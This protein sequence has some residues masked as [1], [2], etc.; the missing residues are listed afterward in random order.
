MPAL[1]LTDARSDFRSRFDEALGGQDANRLAV[2]APR[3]LQTVARR[4][5]AVEQFPR[6]VA[7]GDDQYPKIPRDR[8]VQAERTASCPRVGFR[9]GVARSGNGRRRTRR[10][11]DRL[12]CLFTCHRRLSCL[13][14]LSKLTDRLPVRRRLAVDDRRPPASRYND[15]AFAW[16]PKHDLTPGPP[17]LPAC[18]PLDR[19][20]RTVYSAFMT[21]LF[22]S[23]RS[24]R[25]SR[26]RTSDRSDGYPVDTDS[27]R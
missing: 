3:Y 13:R 25:G 18:V 10:S 5:L 9:G 19:S 17:L 23:L 26:T 22:G 4:D 15:T 7:A 8:S 12:C 11:K 27:C 14:E 16:H 2:G 20:S 21:M 1:R 6:L 24:W